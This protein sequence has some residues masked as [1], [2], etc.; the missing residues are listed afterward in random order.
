M[1]KYNTPEIDVLA[2]SNTDVIMTS[3]Y[4]NAPTDEGE[5]LISVSSS[6]LS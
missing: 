1:K 5:L 4:E 6:F 3:G 2:L